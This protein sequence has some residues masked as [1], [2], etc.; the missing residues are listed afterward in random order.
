MATPILTTPRLTLRP[1]TVFDAA[2]ITSGLSN[3][4]VTSW[5]TTV[6]YPYSLKDA[7]ALITKITE[8]VAGDHWAIDAGTGLIV[9]I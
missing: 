9:V 6:P 2:D 1:I 4:D 7:E 3:A 8:C 5:L